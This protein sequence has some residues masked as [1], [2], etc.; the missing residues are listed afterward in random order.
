MKVLITY[1]CQ[2]KL[3]Y[4]VEESAIEFIDR[5]NGYPD[6][7]YFVM[8]VLEITDERALIWDGHLKGM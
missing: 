3:G 8:N 1:S 7:P 6:G 2:G 5:V 4:S